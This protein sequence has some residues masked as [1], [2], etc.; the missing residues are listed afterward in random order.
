MN[1]NGVS[2]LQSYFDFFY[3]KEISLNMY[4]VFKKKCV[5]CQQSR[6]SQLDHTCIKLTNKQQLE[7]Y[8][9][10][11]LKEV[12]ETQILVKWNETISVMDISPELIEMFKLKIYCR[13]WRET[14]MKTLQWTTK[15]INMTI[16]LLSLENRLC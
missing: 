12:D 14:D 13:D 15:M 9:E 11:I 16:Q 8:F 7:L 1:S 4:A 10:D 6:L 5:E 2:L 3:A